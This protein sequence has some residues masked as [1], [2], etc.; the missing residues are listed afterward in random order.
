MRITMEWLESHD[1][2]WDKW[3]WFPNHYPDGIEAKA[4]ARI[5]LLARDSERLA[6]LAERVDTQVGADEMETTH[7]AMSL[8]KP[9]K[10]DGQ[11]GR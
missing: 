1:A 8:G 10:E 11:E 5:L 3:N 4:L 2:P 9:E 7:C 6:W